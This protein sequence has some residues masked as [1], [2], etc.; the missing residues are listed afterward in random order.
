MQDYRLW[1]V[2]AS[3]VNSRQ[4]PTVIGSDEVVIPD[5]AAEFERRYHE[6]QNDKEDK[7]VG[8]WLRKN[9]GIKSFKGNNG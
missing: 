3:A 8:A 9:S 5:I 7:G 6:M 2:S 1:T 4:G